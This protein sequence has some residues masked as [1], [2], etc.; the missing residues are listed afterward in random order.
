LWDGEI[1]REMRLCAGSKINFS[2]MSYF[3]EA[4]NVQ[5]A[6]HVCHTFHHKLTTK[7]P[8][9][10]VAFSQKPLQKHHSTTTRKKLPEIHR[11]PSREQ[12]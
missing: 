10:A 1:K 5:F 12:G 7:T 8:H 9:T 6:D 2:T 4:K 3:S 11:D